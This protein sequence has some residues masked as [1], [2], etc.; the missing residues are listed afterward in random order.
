MIIDNI[1]SNAINYSR[2]GQRVL[3]SCRA[4][5]DGGATVVVRDYGIGIPPDKLPRIFDDY[6]RTSEAVKHNK[7]STGLGLGHRPRDGLGRQDPRA[8]SERPG[9]GHGLFRARFPRFARANP[10]AAQLTR[11]NAHGVPTDRG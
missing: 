2:D 4:A 7:A 11:R 6:F 9:A 5:A 8:R 3:V 10:R 1:L